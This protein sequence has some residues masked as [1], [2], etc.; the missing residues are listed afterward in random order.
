[1]L[2]EDIKKAINIITKKTSGTNIN[3]YWKLYLNTT[4]NLK[5]YMP[6][7]DINCKNALLPT[8]SGDHHLEAILDGVTN[9][10]SFDINKLAKYFTELKFGA[11]KNFNQDDFI[12]FMYKDTLNKE[13]FDYI[14][15]T[16]NDD[17]RLFWEE[18]LKYRD[19]YDLFHRVSIQQTDGS[20]INGIDFYE[21]C[22]NNFTR[23]LKDDNYK[24]VQNRLL[25]TQINYI[26]SNLL[27]L[28]TK[29]DEKYDFIALSN[30]YEYI[31]ESIFN[32]SSKKFAVIVKLLISNNLNNDGKIIIDY[33]YERGLLDLKKNKDKSMF[34]AYLLNYLCFVKIPII[35]L[36]LYTRKKAINKLNDFREFQWLRYLR[37][38]NIEAYEF[39][40][41]NVA[42][43]YD[44]NSD[45]DMVLVYK[46]K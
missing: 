14:K 41:S 38:I 4:E 12:R 31:N 20:I 46:K 17:V 34:Y 35:S 42:T 26:D 22:V 3:E 8:S 2:E 44:M 37:D 6:H 33:L 45:S 36:K 18:I 19:N 27:E 25:N 40:R 32:D 15:N 28:P 43:K 10:T 7:L 5:A 39:E 13:M 24:I 16:L 30:I 29:L 1:M 23:Y 9:I 11:I 21:Y